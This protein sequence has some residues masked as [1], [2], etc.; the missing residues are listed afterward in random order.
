ME[1]GWES[2]LPA[3][4]LEN[5]VQA[6]R[7]GP[8][9]QIVLWH[10]FVSSF[11]DTLNATAVQ[12]YVAPKARV[13]LLLIGAVVAASAMRSVAPPRAR[14]AQCP[15]AASPR[16]AAARR[17][18]ASPAARAQQQQQPQPPD[19]EAATLRVPRPGK[20]SHLAPSFW[21]SREDTIEA[22]LKAR[23][24]ERCRQCP[25]APPRSLL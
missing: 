1:H 4:T 13:E 19:E 10:L 23:P 6:G 2:T 21:L 22:Q 7:T 11:G 15:T 14:P 17:R 25:H 9:K 5:T 12:A 18:L 24:A 20:P 3:W 8:A 16:L